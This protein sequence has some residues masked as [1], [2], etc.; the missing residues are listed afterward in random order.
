[1]SGGT[2]IE[3]RGCRF[4]AHLLYDVPNHIWYAPEAD[5][6][7]RVGLTEVAVALASRRIF[8]VTPKRVGRAFEAGRSAAMIES[9]KWVGPA[10]LAFDGKVTAIN[11]AL[12]A[13]PAL[14]AEDPYGAGWVMIVRPAGALPEGVLVTGAAIGPAYEAWMGASDFPG[15]APET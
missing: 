4:P 7:L 10:R 11:E 9:S 1:M 13:R 5:G 2:P 8:A 6:T 12:A 15:C 3:V 14:A